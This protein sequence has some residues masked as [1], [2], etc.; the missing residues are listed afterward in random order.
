MYLSRI[1]LYTNNRITQKIMSSPSRIHGEL[2]RCF[3]G[4][5]QSARWRIDQLQGKT[6]LLCLS[7]DKPTYPFSKAE[8]DIRDYNNLLCKLADGQQWYF[9]LCGNPVK[10][11]KGNRIPLVGAN[12]WVDWLANRSKTMGVTFLSVTITS[13]DKLKFKKSNAAVTLQ[14]V[15][16]QGSLRVNDINKLK[17]TL[18]QG[19]GHGKAYGCG[20]LTLA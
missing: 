19:I 5:R 6:Y 2:E 20:L 11:I 15:T 8:W 18:I 10:C 9:K 3:I 13:F 16:Y 1:E 17:N 14:T 12:N 7:E 4:N